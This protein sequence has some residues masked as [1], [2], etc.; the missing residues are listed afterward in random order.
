MKAPVIVYKNSLYQNGSV[1]EETLNFEVQGPYN[2]NV[3][4]Y[5][6]PCYQMG[7][8]NLLSSCPMEKPGTAQEGFEQVR[9]HYGESKN[10]I[11]VSKQPAFALN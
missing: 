4:L 9:L 7:P 1:V 5:L 8:A 3:E 11:V 10:K 6:D 2:A